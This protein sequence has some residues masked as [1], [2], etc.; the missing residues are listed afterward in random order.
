MPTER[1]GGRGPSGGRREQAESALE[2]AFGAS[3]GPV[4]VV[5]APGRANL[6]GGHTDYNEGFVL[7]VAIDRRAVA[8]VRPRE[9]GSVGVH[10]ASLGD[11]V[12]FSL[13]G[14]EPSTG[15]SDYVKGVVDQLQ[16]RGYDLGGA[17]IAVTGD[18][19]LGAGLS[20]SAA[21][22]VAVAGGL[23]VAVDGSFPDDLVDL[24]WAAENEFVG[25]DC[26]VMDQYTAV[27][28]EPSGAL[29]LDCRSVTH[30]TIRVPFELTMVA[31]DTNVQHDLAESAYNERVAT[32]ERAVELLDGA[33][34]QEVAALRDVGVDAFEAHADALPETVRRRARH[35]VN[36]NERVH[37]AAA[38][39][40][41]G[42]LAGVGE[43][44][45][46][47]HASLRDDYGVSVQELDAVVEVAGE[48]DGVYG[49]RMTGAGF[50]GSVLS[51]VRPDDVTSVAAAIRGGYR[52]RTG[53]DPDIYVCTSDGGV[54][55]HGDGG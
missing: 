24:C 52:D 12:E 2:S 23:G 51:L 47:S 31:T 46:A 41:D 48:H 1:D 11:T 19:P 55:R 18:V 32:C 13:D 53:V 45:E 49:S 22:E 16:E 37:E 54:R 3:G 50:G 38:A 29:F 9:D 21:F 15:W 35:V 25:V 39:L 43:L 5:S 42:D 33:L 28:G 10:S 8:A 20:S 40:R 44:L 30:E 14:L 7:P 36:E 34:D 4:T 17:A 26:G 27:H 6:V